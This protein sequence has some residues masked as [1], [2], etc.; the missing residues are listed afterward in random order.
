MGTERAVQ[1]ESRSAQQSCFNVQFYRRLVHVALTF[2]AFSICTGPSSDCVML[3]GLIFLLLCLLS[4]PMKELSGINLFCYFHNIYPTSTG[5]KKVMTFLS[6]GVFLSSLLS[7]SEL[8]LGESASVLTA[9]L[10]TLITNSPYHVYASYQFVLYLYL[11][12][13]FFLRRTCTGEKKNVG[14][15]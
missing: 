9:A 5:H 6:Q 4:F 8:L 14:K 11:C 13:I 2:L 1:L 3:L 7:K 15:M 10:C 12:R